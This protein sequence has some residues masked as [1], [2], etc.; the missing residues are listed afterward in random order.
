M[1]ITDA[2]IRY[3]DDRCRYWDMQYVPS[4]HEHESE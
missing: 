3:L 4:V 1:K 2:L